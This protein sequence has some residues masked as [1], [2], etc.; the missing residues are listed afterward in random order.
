MPRT[1]YLAVCSRGAQPAH[2]AVYIPTGDT[3]DVGKLI[4]VTGNPAQGFFLEFRRNYDFEAPQPSFQRI[5]L[6]QVDDRYIKDTVGNREIGDTIARDRFESVA[7]T[8]QPPS[9]SPNP[10]DPSAPNCQNWL[11]DYTEKL[12]AEGYAPNSA[13]S[14]VR[15][16]PKVL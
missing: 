8:V 4:H 6:A 7:T 1:I 2:Y 16:A 12:V 11:L 10:F 14:V 3:G 13:V 15:N 9:R 5:P